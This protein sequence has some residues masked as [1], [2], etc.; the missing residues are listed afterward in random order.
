M[1]KERL[2]KTSKERFNIYGSAVLVKTQRGTL[3]FHL[4]D[5]GAPSGDAGAVSTFGGGREA[6]IDL[7]GRDYVARELTRDAALREIQEELSIPKEYITNLKPFGYQ[8]F[9]YPDDPDKGFSVHIAEL[10]DGITTDDMT[11]TE[12]AEIVE[13]TL[14]EILE[15]TD[16]FGPIREML[17]R[18][19]ERIEKWIAKDVDYGDHVA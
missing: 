17:E 5:A 2:Y 10:T 14:D 13:G 19:K 18:N 12:G 15:R 16:L 1:E 11:L 3:L 4:K 8:S 7:Q 9:N 6:H